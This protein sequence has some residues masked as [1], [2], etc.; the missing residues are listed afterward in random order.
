MNSCLM[1]AQEED[2]DEQDETPRR[3]KGR[4]AV[5]QQT[6]VCGTYTLLTLYAI[7]D[8]VSQVAVDE[9]SEE[10]VIVAV[11]VKRRRPTDVGEKSKGRDQLPTWVLPHWDLIMAHFLKRFGY[12]FKDPFDFKGPPPGKRF[13]KTLE[14]C[15]TFV[16][17][18]RKYVCEQ[19][20]SDKIY[21][22]VR[23]RSLSL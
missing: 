10:E 2:V 8:I 12:K 14:D 1:C 20:N 9:D 23:T 21:T 5:M 4:S 11:P 17:P 15:I 13:T 3:G 7:N 22:V 16:L 19:K 6:M 18:K